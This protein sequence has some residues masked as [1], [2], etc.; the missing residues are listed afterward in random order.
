LFLD[1]IQAK[2]IA[3]QNVERMR[4]ETEERRVEAEQ[5][6]IAAKAEAFRITTEAEAE[7]AAIELIQAQIAQNQ[8]YIDYLKIIQWNGILP[9]VI[10][11]GVNPF[12]VLGANDNVMGNNPAGPPAQ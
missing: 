5:I 6:E 3:E 1:A 2:V 8:A 12:V 7:A 11:E 10:G 4:H 9:Q